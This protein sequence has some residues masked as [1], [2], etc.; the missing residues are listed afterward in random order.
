M[1]LILSRRALVP[2]LALVVL[3]AI[4]CGS[5]ASAPSDGNP[6][7]GGSS[8]MGTG[9]V[10]AGAG[11]AVAGSGGIVGGTGGI[12][13]G[14]GGVPP[15]GTGG[16]PPGGAGGSMPPG[17]FDAG[18]DP[19]RN[20]VQPGTVCDRFSTVLCAAEQYCCA[21]PGRD[22]NTCKGA[23]TNLCANQLY[24]DTVTLSPLTGYD[25]NRAEAAFTEFERLA[26]MCDP[27]VA[28]WGT[29]ANGLR[30]ITQGTLAPGANCTPDN[31]TDQRA[32]APYLVACTMPE[33]YACLPGLFP[34][35]DWTCA[36]RAGQ[37]SR[38][39]TD[40]NC[41]DGLYCPTGMIGAACTPRKPDGQ[42][43]AS[44]NE[45]ASLLCEGAV[46]VPANQQTAY[47]VNL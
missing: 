21:N 38:C 40:L 35:D 9:G 12:V 45:C 17:P 13:G 19:N 42:P 41:V 15:G 4:G 32:S 3:D 2:A 24:L 18:S 11:G 46:C 43:C 28:Q 44:T 34:T 39:L 1:L 47:C 27:T 25:I 5:D 37:G 7:T 26:S 8:G 36:Q 30:G 31:I 29:T 16:V 14:T 6:T 22:F 10:M 20:I 23:V 33:T